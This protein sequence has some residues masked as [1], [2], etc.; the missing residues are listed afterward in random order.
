M[1]SMIRAR[2]AKGEEP[3]AIRG[4]LI[5]SYGA[6]VSYKPVFDWATAPLWI[7]PALFVL[8]GLWLARGRFRRRNKR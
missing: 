1:R 6:A 5:G 4:M 8:G 7:A 3:E 2:I